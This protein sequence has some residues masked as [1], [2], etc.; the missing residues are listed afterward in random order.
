MHGSRKVFYPAD[1]PVPEN[2]DTRHAL[3]IRILKALQEQ[4]GI[5]VA[6]LALNLG[7]TRQVALYHVRSLGR[8]NLVRL[9]RTR[10]Q[11]RVFPNRPGAP[12]GQAGVPH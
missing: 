6:D 3:Q 8:A 9:E 12:G 11:L 2:G 10:V 7:V 1:T 5:L 4:P